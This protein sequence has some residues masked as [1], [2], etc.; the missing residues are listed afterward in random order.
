MKRFSVVLFAL[1]LL[2]LAAAL[3]SCGK[4]TDFEIVTGEITGDDVT[5]SPE[6]LTES[7]GLA[8]VSNGDGTCSVSGIGD[9]ADADVVIPTL[10]SAGETVTGIKDR[11]FK[12]CKTVTSV[13]I[14]ESV[15][16]VGRFAFYNC[17]NLSSVMI[18]DG[19]KTISE[20]A[21]HGC[22][23]L[24][25][26]S[27]GE[28]VTGFGENCF[29][30]C[31]N[32]TSFTVPTGV[33]TIGNAA[34]FGCSALASVTI[35]DTVTSIG[36]RA[37]S[38][39]ASLPSVVV[40][41]SVKSIGSEAFAGC[42]G[43]ESITLPFIGAKAGLTASDDNLYP[44]GYI[45]GKLSSSGGTSTVQLY[46]E[47]PGKLNQ[48]EY[49]IPSSLKTVTVT[50]GEIAPGAFSNCVNLTAVSLPDGI[51]VIGAYAFYSCV[52]LLTLTLPETV[53]TIGDSAF[54]ACIQLT[55]TIPDG[56]STLGIGAFSGCVSLSP[57]I[58]V[59][60]NM[61][62][63]GAGA[64]AGLSL[65]TSLTVES[66]N[67]VYFSS[68]N[69]LI[70]KGTGKLVAGCNYSTIPTDGSVTSIGEF[71]FSGIVGRMTSVTIPNGVRSLGGYS[72]YYCTTLASVTIPAS[73]TDIGSVAFGLCSALTV[74]RF[75][76]TMAQWNAI[77]KETDWNAETGN[78]TVYCTDGTLSK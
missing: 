38:G 9:C 45:F 35:P 13:F 57:T 24:S 42:T 5:T 46:Q 15:K 36:N 14:P 65:A 41:D 58:V 68:G 12:E 32:L 8:F 39:C 77:N 53:T 19:V 11:A 10:S 26:V 4:E 33:K 70:E 54:A 55:T 18:S 30:N 67:P 27:L 2:I 28:S 21:F 6:P 59:G 22:S 31:S 52:E 78:Y 56:V 48:A 64:F 16:T 25:S 63:I 60:N 69:C 3:I 1:L 44:L 37:F 23:A 72:F 47:S 29:Y 43:L 20:D 50:G 66:G 74:I 17:T 40:P 73:V 76:G 7:E 62:S 71:A 49:Y 61:T 75:E 51:K 34:F